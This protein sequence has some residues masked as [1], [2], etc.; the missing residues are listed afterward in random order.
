MI[1]GVD[2]I[3]KVSV[4]VGVNVIV[5]V[6]VLVGVGVRVGVAVGVGIDS[7]IVP[8]DVHNPIISWIPTIKT[9]AR[10]ATRPP[11]PRE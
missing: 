1:V 8:T 11:L 5:G 2:V 10:I 4:I 9:T 6:L 7:T 3:V